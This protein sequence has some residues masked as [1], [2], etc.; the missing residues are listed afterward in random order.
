MLVF[1]YILQSI[2][3]WYQELYLSNAQSNDPFLC[4]TSIR[5]DP[6]KISN[7]TSMFGTVAILLITDIKQYLNPIIGSIYDVP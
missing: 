3:P 1:L 7:L 6:A 5:T 4:V 2:W